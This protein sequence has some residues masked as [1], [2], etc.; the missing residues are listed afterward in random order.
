MALMVAGHL[1]GRVLAVSASFTRRQPAALLLAAAVAL[2]S[3]LPPTHIHVEAPDDDHDH[4]HHHHH[5]AIEHAHWNAH[6]ASRAAIELGDEEG[7]AIYVDHPA[8]QSRLHA[9]LS[10]PDTVV[11][12]L[13]VAAPPATYASSEQREAGNA[14]RD[15]PSREV[16]T[17]RGP[18]IVL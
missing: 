8:R 5:G 2:A 1:E 12:A 6:G 15:G 4:H 10:R 9:S 7:A 16:P 3:A 11:V 13:L 17:L 14:P 18:P